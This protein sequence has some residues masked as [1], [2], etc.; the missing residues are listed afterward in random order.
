MNATKMT[1][2][3]Q[4]LYDLIAAMAR[5]PENIATAERRNGSA[6][7]MIELHVHRADYGSVNG[8]MGKHLTAIRTIFQFI[9]AREKRDIKVL[10]LESTVGDREERLPFVPKENWPEKPTLDL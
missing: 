4:L 8:S 2:D 3:E 6:G 5:H 1:P 9:G 10:L 7:T